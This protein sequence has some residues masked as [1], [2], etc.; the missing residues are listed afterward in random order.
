M[1]VVALDR[2]QET[3][4]AAGLQNVGT[5]SVIGRGGLDRVLRIMPGAD[6]RLRCP[7]HRMY[8]M[9]YFN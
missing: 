3:L 8:G 1:Q 6:L 9:L 2:E 4:A 7:Q 5:T